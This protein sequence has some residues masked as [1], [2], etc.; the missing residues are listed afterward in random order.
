MKDMLKF[1]DK[2]RLLLVFAFSILQGIA[3]Y[4]V[5]FCFSY[6]ATSPLIN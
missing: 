6:F 3:A 5:S 4:A 2:K 1:V